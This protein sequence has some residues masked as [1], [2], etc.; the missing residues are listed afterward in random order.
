METS[1]A[2]ATQERIWNLSAR[3]SPQMGSFIS[4]WFTRVQSRQNSKWD[5]SM[6]PTALCS[7]QNWC[8]RRVEKAQSNWTQACSQ[9]TKT[10][11]AAEA[12]SKTRLSMLQL[13][14]TRN[15]CNKRCCLK[16]VVDQLFSARIIMS[17][18]MRWISSIWRA[19][20]SQNRLSWCPKTSLPTA[21]V[22]FPSRS[23]STHPVSEMVW[24]SLLVSQDWRD[25]LQLIGPKWHLCLI[26]LEVCSAQPFK[27]RF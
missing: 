20:R 9:P 3:R 21:T 26:R 11:S 1:T 7:N 4:I 2:I 6:P 14:M 15:Q 13:K 22:I 12:P 5:S 24:A 27:G 25:F 8:R 10:T 16:V 18:K 19:N 23:T 17:L